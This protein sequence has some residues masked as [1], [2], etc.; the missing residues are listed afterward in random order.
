MLGSPGDELRKKYELRCT[1]AEGVAVMGLTEEKVEK[2]GD[3]DRWMRAAQERR[4]AL[5]EGRGGGKGGGR[6]HL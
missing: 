6:S 3:L 5:A 2:T 4:R 1:E